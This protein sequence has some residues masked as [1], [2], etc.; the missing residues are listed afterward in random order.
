MNRVHGPAPC[1]STLPQ[2]HPLFIHVVTVKWFGSMRCF[3]DDHARFSRRGGL[4]LPFIPSSSCHKSSAPNSTPILW[5][6]LYRNY[7]LQQV[8]VSALVTCRSLLGSR[9]AAVIVTALSV[10]LV[11]AG[12]TTCISR[13]LD[14]YTSV[15]GESP[16]KLSCW[17]PSTGAHELWLLLNRHDVSASSSNM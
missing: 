17:M 4:Y 7:S 10:G 8:M 5:F 1:L 11:Q 2:I 3:G 14:W 9:L 13:Q 16:C 15:V 12:N 6:A